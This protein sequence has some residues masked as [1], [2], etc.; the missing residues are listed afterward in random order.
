MFPRDPWVTTQYT[1]TVKKV[2]Y[3]E[4]SSGDPCLLMFDRCNG[5]GRLPPGIPGEGRDSAIFYL[6]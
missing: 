5:D 3:L 6:R 2:N 1:N 4:F